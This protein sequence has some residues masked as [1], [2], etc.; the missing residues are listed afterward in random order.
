MYSC[1]HFGLNSFT[2]CTSMCTASLHHK[3]HQQGWIGLC[4]VLRPRQHSIGYMGDG[5]HRSKDP[6]NSIK[7]LKEKSSPGLWVLSTSDT[8]TNLQHGI[9]RS[10]DSTFL[11][12]FVREWYWDSTVGLYRI[13]FF[14]FRLE[15]DFAGF[16]MTNPTGAGFSNWL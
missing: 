12:F 10:P 2:S 9:S 13:Y 16:R 4:S 11:P 6:S 8:S 5:L 7:V 3:S 1:G 15:L 14:P